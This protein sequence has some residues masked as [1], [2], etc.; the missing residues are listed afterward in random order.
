MAL[1]LDIDLTDSQKATMATLP[2][3]AWFTQVVYRNAESPPHPDRFGVHLAT[4][5][6]AKQALVN[7]WI[8][9]SVKGKRV[10]DLFSANGAFSAIAA[11][12]GAR[13]VVGVE[14][15]RERI[16]CAE[17]VASTLRTACSISF[18]E[19]DVYRIAEYFE[20]PFDVVLCLGGLYHIADPAFL[21]RE[22][23]RLTREC[24]I[25][26]TDHVLPARGNRAKFV[27]RRHDWTGQG[28]TSSCGGDG[29]W[30][31]SRDC[32]HELLLHGGFR[33]LEERRPP[34]WGRR[35]LPWYAA[36]CEPLR[37]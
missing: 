17:F 19:G 23:G 6:V 1:K 7:D 31:Y 34:G 15:S 9:R 18:R 27:V 22:M 36:R 12:A 16:R 35:R 8:A 25:L 29:T 14:F 21:L 24:L 28:M 32:L 26:Q 20:E 30:H 13:E 33:V 5:N 10:L 37:G 2:A 4:K 3:T 11:M